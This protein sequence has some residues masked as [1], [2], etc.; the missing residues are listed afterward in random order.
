M[1]GTADTAV[2]RGF[3][4]PSTAEMSGANE[5]LSDL[6]EAGESGSARRWLDGTEARAY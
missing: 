1:I 6:R 4:F 3:R 2:I 5:L